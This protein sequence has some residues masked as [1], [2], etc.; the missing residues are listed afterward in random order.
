MKSL[1]HIFPGETE[2]NLLVYCMSSDG[3]SF[4]MEGNAGG[5]R[6]SNW[7]ELAC[8]W[9]RD[10]EH[11][12]M[13]PFLLLRSLDVQS[14]RGSESSAGIAHPAVRGYAQ[15]RATTI[16]GL[17]RGV[18]PPI[19]EAMQMKWSKAFPITRSS[20]AANSSLRQMWWHRRRCTRVSTLFRP[21]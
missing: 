2:M 13:K 20:P 1:Y 7:R 19:P 11:D 12:E 4:D 14:L 21:C 18:L 3:C 16:E 5:W 10:E 17:S 15:M 8:S 6:P 9:L